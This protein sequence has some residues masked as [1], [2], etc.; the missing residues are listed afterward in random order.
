MIFFF[1]I[2]GKVVDYKYV[3]GATFDQGKSSIPLKRWL[4]I[5]FSLDGAAKYVNTVS[6]VDSSQL[7][8]PLCAST[9]DF[10]CFMRQNHS[11]LVHLFKCCLKLFDVLTL[12][13]VDFWFLADHYLFPNCCCFG[14]VTSSEHRAGLKSW[15]G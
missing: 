3:N 11:L 5:Y 8:F 4:P 2:R 15:R 1:F 6:K 12:I 10:R 13:R 7:V 14:L 9:N